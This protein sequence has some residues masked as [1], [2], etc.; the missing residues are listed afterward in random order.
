MSKWSKGKYMKIKLVALAL[1]GVMVAGTAFA[2]TDLDPKFYVGAELQAN[3]SSGTKKITDKNGNA[4]QRSDNK[5]L[6]KKSGVSASAIVGSRLND[7]VGVEA[8][9]SAMSGPKLRKDKL[10]V[11]VAATGL[12]APVTLDGTKIKTKNHNVHFDAL[13]FVPVDEQIDLIGSIGVGRL[14]TKI[15]LLTAGASTETEKSSKTGL[16]A[17]VG[18][19]YKF[20][21][22]LSAR[23]MVR[24]QKGNKLVKNITQAG[25]GL[26][27]N[28]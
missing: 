24:H 23:L 3:K 25:L 26:F 17:G 1:S 7:F 2:G 22:C 4:T 5:S 27:Y 18:V 10:T 6:F 19:G 16:R 28:F 11:T 14:S 8:G 9:Y 15:K 12:T 20:D 21:D 13:G